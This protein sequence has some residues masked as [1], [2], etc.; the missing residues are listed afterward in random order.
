[1]LRHIVLF[2]WKAEVTAA[3]V[4][5][6]ASALANLPEAIPEVRFFR[7]GPDAG[8]NEGNFDF[9]VVADFDD[10]TGY[11][12]YRDHPAHYSLVAERIAPILAERAAVQFEFEG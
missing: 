3:E 7:F 12:A 6:V 10:V 9:S 5:P 11:L 4:R 8:L 2:R 1:M